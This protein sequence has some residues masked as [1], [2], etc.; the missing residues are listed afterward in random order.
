ME[1]CL[2]L[3]AR[4]DAHLDAHPDV[5]LDVHPENRKNI[6]VYLLTAS[7]HNTASLSIIAGTT[8]GS[9]KGRSIFEQKRIVY[10]YNICKQYASA[11]RYCDLLGY[12]WN[13]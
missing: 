4:L 10:L 8:I 12:L 7:R 11:H 13:H 6:K 3:D 2:H 1:A 9:P 5:R